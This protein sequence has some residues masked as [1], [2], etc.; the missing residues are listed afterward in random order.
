MAKR[1]YYGEEPEKKER[2]N[3]KKMTGLDCWDVFKGVSG[4]VAGGCASAVAHRY[5]KAVVPS[6]GNVAEKAVIAIG[7][8]FVTGFVG[9]KVE[10][11]VMS[12]VDDLKNTLGT[13]KAAKEETDVDNG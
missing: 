8:Y 9:H 2:P 3:F 11:Y 7:V 12:E 13:L 1:H 6:G 4:L 10:Q 5:L